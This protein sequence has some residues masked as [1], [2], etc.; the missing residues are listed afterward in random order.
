ME[1]VFHHSSRQFNYRG[2]WR[3]ILKQLLEKSIRK[4][5]ETNPDPDTNPVDSLE[6]YY[7]FIDR[8]VKALPW[9]ISPHKEYSSLYTS[10]DQGMGCL[11]FICNQPLE[12]LE[13]KGYFHN[14]LQYHEPFR[15]WWIKMLSGYGQFL[16]TEDS[17]NDE[18]YENVKKDPAFDLQGNTYEDPW[19]WICF[20]D[21]FA[22]RLSDPSVRPIDGKDDPSVVVSPA[23][24]KPQGFW[25]IDDTG[26]IIAEIG[27]ENGISIKTGKLTD[28]DALL[29]G[30]EY[31]EKFYGGTITH[32]FLD[33]TD[34]HRYHFPVSG[35]VKEVRIIAQDD[36]AGGVI[37]WDEK[38]K[39]Y[40]EYFSETIGWQSIETRGLVVVEIEGGGYAAILPVGMCQV[41]SVNFEE[42]VVNG[43]EVKK[44]D[45]LGFFL[46][47]GSDV[48][49]IFSEDAGFNM[50]AEAGK[51]VLM[52]NEIGRLERSDSGE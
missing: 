34:Y 22:R 6:S 12:E 36:A 40:Y 39:C 15:S 1:C 20:N 10:I 25:Q 47:G 32:T 19:S 5:R 2:S 31:A 14:S 35:T 37:V 44:G 7:S 18:Y 17:W 24:S 29:D 38:N 11:Y 30:S 45:P 41:S 4:G 46:F 13:D 52:G 49:M 43:A 33:I 3:E 8:V 42:S 23:D 50:T 21:F 48:I 9:E 51:H 27:E 26:R 28:I 16:N